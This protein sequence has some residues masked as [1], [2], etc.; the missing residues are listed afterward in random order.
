MY[1]FGWNSSV[2]TERR[3]LNWAILFRRDTVC[4]ARR[5]GSLS[6]WDTPQ[7]ALRENR[8]Y[9]RNSHTLPTL[10]RGGHVPGRPCFF[11]EQLML[12][13]DSTEKPI[14][15]LQ[16]VK[17]VSGSDNL[18]SGS[19]LRNCFVLF[20]GRTTKVYSFRLLKWSYSY[21]CKMK[22]IGKWKNEHL[23]NLW[24]WSFHIIIGEHW[25]AHI[26][27]WSAVRH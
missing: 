22:V 16:N 18:A 17:R 1:N 15:R 24:I 6:D 26:K 12:Q 8:S 2:I 9:G 23:C 7:A 11:T 20:R 19:Y 14:F 27:N 5:A 10:V 4:T 3:T 13:N 21:Q 25:C